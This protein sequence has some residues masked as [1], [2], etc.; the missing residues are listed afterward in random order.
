MHHFF[1]FSEIFYLIFHKLS[2]FPQ[3]FIYIWGGL[4]IFLYFHITFAPSP[5]YRINNLVFLSNPVSC[6]VSDI[7]KQIQTTIASP[8][9]HKTQPNKQDKNKN[10]NQYKTNKKP[11]TFPPKFFP[12]PPLLTLHRY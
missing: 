11:F 2:S 1:F 7:E 8:F 6:S 12:F 5:A 3:H 9:P 4:N 10:K